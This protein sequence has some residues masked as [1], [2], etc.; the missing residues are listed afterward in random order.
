[1]FNSSTRMAS[2]VLAFGIFFAFSC[3]TTE[4]TVTNQQNSSPVQS[5]DQQLQEL[6][7]RIA[8]SPGQGELYIKKAKILSEYSAT[9][10][11]PAQ[12]LPLYRNLKD[13]SLSDQGNL[14]EIEAI[15]KSAWNKE[16]SSGL[17]ELQEQTE[18]NLQEHPSIIA[19]FDNAITLIPDSLQTYF[20]KATTLYRTGNLHDAI[21]T[22]ETAKNFTAENHSEID[23]KIAY[24][25]LESGNVQEAISMYNQLAETYPDV[26]HYQ[27]GL[28]N[29]LIINEQHEDA[30]TMLR[31]LSE[32]YPVRFFYRESLATE[33]YFLVK[34]ESESLLQSDPDQTNISENLDRII[35]YLDESHEL[36]NS[37]SSQIPV[38]EEG[39][40]R[41]AAFYKNSA[42]LLGTLTDEL[43][44]KQDEQEMLEDRYINFLEHS[45]PL[46]ERLTE[47]NPDN[48]D[49]ILNLQEVYRT[50]GMDEEADAIERSITF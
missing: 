45:L 26:E 9:F 41:I 48:M 23:E 44:L 20:L 16:H 32:T 29:A 6:N 43:P 35:S 5:Y 31:E 10:S 22:L 19:H 1:M 34:K 18:T 8:E 46:W 33:T 17:R 49:Y 13:L 11:N 37:L 25:N 50:L 12:R 36:F 21:G 38:H 24:L 39:T 27:N 30:I 3:S 40:L 47:M 2:L 42:I 7:Y 4:T 15:I 14:P 28:I